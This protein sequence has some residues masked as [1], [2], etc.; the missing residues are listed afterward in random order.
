MW[1]LTR[2]GNYSAVYKGGSVQV[3]AR[4][5]DDLKRLI[6]KGFVPKGTK[7]IETADGRSDYRYRILIDHDQ[8]ASACEALARDI[9]YGNFK[10][11]VMKSLG[12]KRER[13]LHS[14]WSILAKLQ[15]GG[16]YARKG[17]RLKS[18]QVSKQ[19]QF[20]LDPNRRGSFGAALVRTDEVWIDELVDDQEMRLAQDMPDEEWVSARLGEAFS[21]DEQME[22]ADALAAPKKRKRGGR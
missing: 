9:D 15:P 7:I 4:V 16:A 8:W 11:E 2:Y 14:I 13:P 19:P 10:S 6:D 17:D 5:R 3:R 18:S 1:M 12:A 21:E 22:I 20:D